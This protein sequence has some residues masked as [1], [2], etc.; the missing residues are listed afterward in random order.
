MVRARLEVLDAAGSVVVTADCDVGETLLDVC[1]DA[2]AGIPF[3]CRHASCGS[4]VVEVLDGSEA[5]A[6]PSRLELSVLG[7]HG[8]ATGDRLACRAVFAAA[9]VVRIRARRTSPI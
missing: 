1:D 6:E 4:C 7:Q 3:G 8:V 5:L 9:R 2:R